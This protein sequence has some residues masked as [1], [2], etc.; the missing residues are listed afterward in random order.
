MNMMIIRT[1]IMM[2][3]ATINAI[4][5][6][7]FMVMLIV[8]IHRQHHHNQQCYSQVLPTQGARPLRAPLV[9]ESVTLTNWLSRDKI[10]RISRL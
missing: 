1:L 7:L 5:T 3:K 9:H 4:T 6:V 8:V 2:T 10:L